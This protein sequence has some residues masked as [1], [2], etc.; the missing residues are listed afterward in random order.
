M[1]WYRPSLHCDGELRAAVAD[2]ADDEARPQLEQDAG[3]DVVEATGR[4]CA[5][6]RSVSLAS[7]VIT[8]SALPKVN[9]TLSAVPLMSWEMITSEPGSPRPSTR[10]R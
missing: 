8:R 2:E 9:R 3:V 10:G 4:C 5:Y 1:I 6:F 7:A